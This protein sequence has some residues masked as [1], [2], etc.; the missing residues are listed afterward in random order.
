MMANL[1]LPTIEFIDV[2]NE[3]FDLAFCETKKKN[4]DIGK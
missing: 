4:K 2:S 3:T 1:K